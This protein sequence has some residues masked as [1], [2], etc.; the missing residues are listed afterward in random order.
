VSHYDPSSPVE[1]GRI[2]SKDT[3]ICGH[4]LLNHKS[5][6]AQP[7]SS[8]VLR[9]PQCLKCRTCR[10]FRYVPSR[11]E[12]VGMGY[13]CRRKQ[14]SLKEFQERLRKAPDTY[15]CLI[16]N[17][18]GKHIL[19]LICVL[20]WILTCKYA[21]HHC[22]LFSKVSDHE[23][24]FETREERVLGDKPVDESFFPLHEHSHL[25]DLVFP[26]ESHASA[27]H[28]F[29]EARSLT[30]SATTSRCSLLG[31]DIST[32][33]IKSLPPIR[34]GAVEVPIRVIPMS[35]EP[36]KP[37][38][39]T[40]MKPVLLTNFGAWPAPIADKSRWKPKRWAY[41]PFSLSDVFIL[42]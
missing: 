40:S 42:T 20:R 5:V 17:R 4:T 33:V 15:C 39:L 19:V 23:T 9:P 30:I 1:C 3:C 6:V 32:P 2:S 21:R 34:L 24:L 38:P 35:D 41:S 26:S 25:S 31:D 8:K 28:D 14:F 16:C 29:V 22:V 7:K 11:P 37:A 12:E 13:L 36:N 10:F 27:D 18:L